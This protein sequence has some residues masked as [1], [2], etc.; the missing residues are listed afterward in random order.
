VRHGFSVR[1]K[2]GWRTAITHQV[3]LMQRDGRRLAIPVLTAGG[4]P[5]A[6]GADTIERVAERLLRRR[7]EARRQRSQ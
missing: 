3:A 6:Y 7:S 2:R 5:M 4:P 1:L